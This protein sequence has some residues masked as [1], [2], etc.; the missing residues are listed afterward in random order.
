ME[1]GKWK[2]ENGKHYAQ[3][4]SKVSEWGQIMENGKWKMKRQNSNSLKPV[5]KIHADRVSRL[6][7]MWFAEYGY[8]QRLSKVSEWGEI[9]EN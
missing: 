2:M 1:N 5:S 3:R 7:K 6:S 4:L 9:I 8:T